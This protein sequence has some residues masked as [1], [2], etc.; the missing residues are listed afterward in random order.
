MLLTITLN[1]KIGFFFSIVDA[2]YNNP[3]ISIDVRFIL[4]RVIYERMHQG[5]EQ[6]VATGYVNNLFPSEELLLDP[7]VE[8]YTLTRD[9]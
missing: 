6:V 7:V 4:G 9:E 5:I 8:L 1:Y 3:E 2:V